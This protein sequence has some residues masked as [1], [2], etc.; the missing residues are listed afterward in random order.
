MTRHVSCGAVLAAVDLE[1]SY[2]GCDNFVRVILRIH[3]SFD[4]YTCVTN[5]THDF[6]SFSSRLSIM[7]LQIFFII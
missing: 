6:L 2:V 1:Q 4:S 5:M 7:Y 3:V